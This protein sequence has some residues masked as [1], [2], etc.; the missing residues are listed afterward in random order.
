MQIQ[1]EVCS[2]TK[3][4]SSQLN[5]YLKSWNSIKPSQSSI[6]YDVVV[7]KQMKRKT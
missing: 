3:L 6:N 1:R 7:T 2:Q 4:S 5:W